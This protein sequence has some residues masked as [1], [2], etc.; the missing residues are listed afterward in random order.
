MESTTDLPYSPAA[1]RNQ[2]P[3]LEVLKQL[4][5]SDVRVL[6]IGS[7][8]GQHAVA[9]AS[10]LPHVY[11]QTSERAEI[12]PSLTRRLE[13]EAPGLPAPLS[14]DVLTGPWPA[15]QYDFVF[16]ANTAHIMSWAG[17]CAML[18]GAAGLLAPGGSML[19]Y[20]PFTQNGQYNAYSNELFDRQLRAADA[21]QG[22]RD[23]NAL[24]IEAQG[25]GMRLVNLIDLPANNRIAVFTKNA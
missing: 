2:A 4:L 18:K 15:E 23:L 8:T 17:V 10:A 3:I 9:F 14:L 6:E 21:R 22:I 7:G 13:Q 16:T 24:G 5:A 20:G 12:L 19:I 11:W 1:E 25:N